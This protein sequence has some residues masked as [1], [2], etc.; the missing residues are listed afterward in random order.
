MHL[1]ADKGSG[2][3]EQAEDM[4]LVTCKLL[5]MGEG[6]AAHLNAAAVHIALRR[7]RADI[8]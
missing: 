6:R 7:S 4:Q 3:G 5:R 2:V 1:L 8:I